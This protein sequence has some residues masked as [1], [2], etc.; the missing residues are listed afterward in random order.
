MDDYELGPLLG[1]GGMGEVHIARHKGRVVAVKR[2]RKTL[3]SDRLLRA[4]LGD[5]R[6]LLGRIDH[7]NV[8]SALGGGMDADGQ[9][10][11]MMSRAY[12]APLDAAIAT[13]PLTRDRIAA[14]SSQLFA[15]LIAIHE[16]RVIHGDLKSSN[17]MVDEID[18]VT[19]IDFGLA[20]TVTRDFQDDSLFA[21]TPAYMAPEVMAGDRPSIAADIFAAGII[22]YE[23]LTGS[24]PIPRNLPAT[25]VLTLR[26]DAPI[27]SP[28]KRAP[29]RG[30][31]TQL[32]AVLHCA[33]DRDPAA[34]FPTARAFGNALAE[35]LASW[36]SVDSVGPRVEAQPVDNEP[37]LV[38]RDLSADVIAES[39]SAAS[40]RIA[41][42][43]VKGAVEVLE[44]GL[45]RLGQIVPSRVTPIGPAAWR[46][47]TV[48]AALY[49]SLGKK[50]HANRLARAAYQHALRTG[51]PVAEARTGALLGQLVSGR[52]RVAR[53]S[54]EIVATPP[55]PWPRARKR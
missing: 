2:V 24:T 52:R 3:S 19:I 35:A 7:A 29:A 40:A 32:D 26:I 21:G 38:N 5:E 36:T 12:G 50:D 17:V 11:L 30:L 39:L 37:T 46:I 4:R 53:G 34:R 45:V 49:D 55:S 20:R 9:P 13:G 1:R 25:T 33:L 54:A 6:Q 43:D 27:E 8:V 48:L 16:A 47:E 15:G 42:R 10:Y 28:S 22:V 41:K 31:T 51:C 18:R 44:H 14:I 23:M